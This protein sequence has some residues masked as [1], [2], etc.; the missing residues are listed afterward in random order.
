M[1]SVAFRRPTE[2][3]D[4]PLVSGVA[5]RHEDGGVGSVSLEDVRR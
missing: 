4:A 2:G 5:E 3:T 1:K